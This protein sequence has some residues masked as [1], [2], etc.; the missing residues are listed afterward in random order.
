[1][2]TTNNPGQHNNF[3]FLRF[4]FAFS[5]VLF[6]LAWLTRDKTLMHFFG[7]IDPN[8]PVS[9][10]FIISGF[11]IANSY[12]RSAS[13]KSYF[14]KRMHRLLPAYIVV[15]LICT[16]SL[17]IV[18]NLS[19]TAYF[20]NNTTY[21]YLLDNLIFLNFLQPC[22]PGVFES[23]PICAVNGALW[24]IKIE[25]CFYLILPLLCYV[26]KKF[27]NKL[28]PLLLL[29]A[30]VL[31]HNYALTRFLQPH[32]PAI[33]G[34]LMHQLPALMTYFISGMVL[35]YY[36]DFIFK[37]KVILA[38][39]ALPVF[40][41]E[42]LNDLEILRPISFGLLIFYLAY[43]PFLKSLN[44]FSRYGDFSYGIYIFHFP[45]IQLFVALG[46]WKAGSAIWPG[47]FLCLLLILVT[48]VASWHLIEKRFLSA[49]RRAQTVLL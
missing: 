49:R 26:L 4:A 30:I 11:L 36:F 34:L 46:V 17:S 41:V 29:Y 8:M 35:H 19:F 45:I 18:S 9:G 7:G 27:R 31:L 1:M 22:L 23:N 39:A 15:V 2:N 28:V 21:K 40:L 38:L 5:V 6:H 32:N 16:V 24:T 42:Y 47:F 12:N 10:F 44:R 3:D 37:Y 14:V 25:V 20:S 13:L 43:T 33:Y 48:G